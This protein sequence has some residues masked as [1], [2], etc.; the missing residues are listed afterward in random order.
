MDTLISQPP[1]VTFSQI[2]FIFARH[3]SLVVY[4]YLALIDAYL[5]VILTC[6]AAR[7]PAIP[8]WHREYHNHS[9]HSS[10]LRPT[11]HCTSV[12]STPVIIPMW[13]VPGVFNIPTWHREYHNHSDSSSNLRPQFHCISVQ[14]TPVIIPNAGV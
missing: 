12:L 14:S 3:G 7:S 8:T 6:H 10:S 4:T 5:P 11:F 13:G 1:S 9:D 2:T